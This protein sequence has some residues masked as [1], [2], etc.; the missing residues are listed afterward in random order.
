MTCFLL[1]YYFNVLKCGSGGGG[2]S[3]DLKCNVLLIGYM[4]CEKERQLQILEE[5]KL[6]ENYEYHQSM[7]LQ[8][9]LQE[10][11]ARRNVKPQ[12]MMLPSFCTSCSCTREFNPQVTNQKTVLI[13]IDQSEDSIDIC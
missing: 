7:L 13:M 8:V 4:S 12:P 10:Q 3:K 5:Q 9:Q 1:L 11:L 6:K 2:D